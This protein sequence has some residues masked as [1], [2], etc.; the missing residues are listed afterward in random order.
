MNSFLNK[1]ASKFVPVA[2]IK[3][4]DQDFLNLQYKGRD[5]QHPGINF[6]NIIASYHFL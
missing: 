6:V 1:L 2:K 3:A 5:N 4:A